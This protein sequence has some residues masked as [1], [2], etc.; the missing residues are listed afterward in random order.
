MQQAA[1]EQGSDFDPAEFDI[2]SQPDEVCLDPIQVKKDHW[3]TL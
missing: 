3:L 1:E 2:H